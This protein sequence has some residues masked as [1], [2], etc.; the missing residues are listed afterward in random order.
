MPTDKQEWWQDFMDNIESLTNVSITR[1]YNKFVLKICV[2]CKL[3]KRVDKFITCSFGI[4][5]LTLHGL[6]TS[7]CS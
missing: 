2:V 4:N 1:H 5:N 3:N 6:I 7:F